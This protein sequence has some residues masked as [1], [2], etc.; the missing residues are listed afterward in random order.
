MSINIKLLPFALV[1]P[2]LFIVSPP[3]YSKQSFGDYE[4]A[5]YVRNYDG[6]TITFNLPTLHPIIGKNISIRVNGIDTPEIRGECEKETYNAE[7]ARDMVSEIL[8]DAGQIA[9]KN[10]KRGKYFRIV[11]DVYV[12]EENLAVML[13][14]AGVAIP[15]SGGKKSKNW[16]E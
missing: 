14:E 2:F 3:A 8:K 1:F 15:Y 10:L 9:L 16:C 4:G 7:Q 11:A 5:V 12:D 13:V 6:D